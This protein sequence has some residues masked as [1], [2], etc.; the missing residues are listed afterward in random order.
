MVDKYKCFTDFSWCD[1]ERP[2]IQIHGHAATVHVGGDHL[3]EISAAS[4][5]DLKDQL[6]GY[7]EI[8]KAAS[9]SVDTDHEAE[10]MPI[11]EGTREQLNALGE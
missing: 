5:A 1:D 11:F 9:E 6:A 7:S 3:L 2:E 8:F 10:E 4:N